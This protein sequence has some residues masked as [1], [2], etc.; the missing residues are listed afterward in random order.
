MNVKRIAV[1]A[2]GL[3]LRRGVRCGRDAPVPAVPIASAGR[4]RDAALRARHHLVAW[5]VGRSCRRRRPR[6]SHSSRWTSSSSRRTT[7]LTVASLSE[8]LGLVVF[9]IVA[10][11]SGQ[12]TGQL[13]QR[14]RAAVQRQREL[15]L[16]NTLSFRIAVREVRP[17]IAELHRR[18]E[19]RTS[20]ARNARRSTSGRMGREHPPA[21]PRRVTRGRRRERRRSWSWVLRNGKAIGMRPPN[22]TVDRMGG[23]PPSALAIR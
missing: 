14:E 11:V 19:S 9:L 3:P 17:S 20:W 22:R 23:P 13:R 4:H 15:E 18:T 10:L 1:S 16:L 12:Q 8:W 6:C 2:G 7:D 5:F 21:S